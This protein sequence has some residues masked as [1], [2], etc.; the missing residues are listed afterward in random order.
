MNRALSWLALGVIALGALEL[1]GVQA[2]QPLENRVLDRYV[3]VQAAKLA[4]D[5][6]IV[7]IDIDEKSL[8]AMEKEAGRWPWP[9]VVYAELV[10]GLAAQKPRAIV[11]DILF[12]E[13]DRFRP[14][15]DEAFAAAVTEHRNTYFPLLR[16]PASGDARGVPMTEIAPLIGVMRGKG[17]D[18]EA[19]AALVPPMV[20][21]PEQWRVGLIGFSEDAD[22]VGRRYTLRETIRGWQVPSL[23]ARVAFDL[24]YPVPDVDDIVL[25]WRGAKGQFPHVSFSDLYEDFNRS[26]RA[27]PADE[28]T[29]KILIIGAAA[30]GLQDLRVTPLDS[31]HPGAEI[32]GTAIEN[33]KNGRQMRYAATWWPAL[34]GVSLIF[35]VT[36]GF[37][38]GV[39]ARITGGTL[40]AAS[41]GLVATS[42]ALVG[43]LVLLPVVTPL[44]AAWLFFG[45]A[46]LAEFLR[47]RRQ[48]QAAMAQFS[49]FTNP[50]VAKLLVD[51]G[52]IETA[53][54]EVTLLFSDI[55]GF[56]TLS[57]TR[58]PEEVIALL[59][60]YFS[61][62]VDVVFRHGGSLDKFIGDCIMAIWGAPLDDR[63]HAK[64]AVACALDMVDTLI[65]FRRALGAEDS[66]FD[67]GIGVHS[68]PA[69]VGLMGSQKR[70]EYTAI[71]DTVNLASRIESLTKDAKRRVLVSKDTVELC[72]DAF[73]FEPCGTFPVKGRAQPVELYEPRRRA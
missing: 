23:P 49:R 62:Q 61:L 37:R 43:S 14:Q 57:E 44:A 70:L 50:H 68:G 67:V 16:L 21:P 55:R 7:L 12:T 72:G 33:L 52:G 18:P 10:E 69:V 53:R 58:S 60:R 45:T 31:L 24:G 48:R 63:D 65:A 34:I 73:E 39:D 51:R 41:V 17:A 8:A 11:F 27:R 71:G 6:D 47:E 5:P 2:L 28:F 4:P 1:F 22:G 40:A 19:R 56:T 29:G 15:E 35:L 54:R 9:R 64:H 66:G 38:T 59:N 46:A 36:L 20:L 42:W 30:S 32:L 3:R 13:A 26:K 25:A